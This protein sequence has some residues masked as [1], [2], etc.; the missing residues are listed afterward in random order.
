MH[1]SEQH[2][3]HPPRSDYV[4]T[5][6]FCLHLWRPTDLGAAIPLPPRILV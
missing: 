3:I 4:N 1:F 2:R 5:H 6:A